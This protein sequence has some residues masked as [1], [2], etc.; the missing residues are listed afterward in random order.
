MA[1]FDVGCANLVGI[2]TGVMKALC[3]T[4]FAWET[5]HGTRSG[6]PSFADF[7]KMH[8]K[9]TSPLTI[10]YPDVW[11]FDHPYW[12]FINCKHLRLFHSDF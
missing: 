10:E 6:N 11:L 5:S 1:V 7:A 4:G 3:A 2:G 8:Q 12:V 9:G